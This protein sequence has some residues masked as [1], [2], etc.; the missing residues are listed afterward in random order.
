MGVVYRARD[1][2]LDRPVA[3]KVLRA[4][5]DANE[6]RFL[7]EVR[8]LARFSHANLVRLLDAGDADGRPYLVMDLVD[9]ETLSQRLA[10]TGIAPQQSARIGADVSR[11]LAYVHEQGVVHRDVKPGNVLLDESGVA[12][13]TDF[14]IARLIDTTGMTATGLTLGTP[15]YL[16][17]EQIQGGVVGPAADVYALGLVLVECLS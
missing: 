2:R 3:V 7:A 15:A 16:A 8:I 13:L 5:E 12:Y 17:P 14:G 9:G 4:A 11:A 10:S 1:T 6:E